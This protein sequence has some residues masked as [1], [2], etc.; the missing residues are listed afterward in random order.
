M[1]SNLT[2]HEDDEVLKHIMYAYSF[3][4]SFSV[5]QELKFNYYDWRN[6]YM[7]ELKI[8]IPIKFLNKLSETEWGVIVNTVILNVQPFLECSPKFFPEYTKHGIDH[9]N[10]VIEITENLIPDSVIN[11]NKLL[12]A[13]DI[14]IL[15]C[16][17][18]IHDLSMFIDDSQFSR[19]INCNEYVCPIK[20]NETNLNL[21]EG[22]CHMAKRFSTE[23]W[24]SLL[25]MSYNKTPSLKDVGR[26]T[27]RDHLFIGD[28]LRLYHHRF[29]FEIALR[30]FIGVE[31]LPQ[32]IDE[33]RK[34]IIGLIAYSHCVKLRDIEIEEYCNSYFGSTDYVDDCPIYYLMV[35][36]R[37]SD[38]LDAGIERAPKE[39]SDIHIFI[40]ETS[41]KEWILNQ[42]FR[43]ESFGW[44]KAN[45]IHTLNLPVTPHSTTE[46][47]NIERRLLGI[48]KEFDESVAVLDEI[49][50]GEYSLTVSR[51]TSNIFKNECRDQFAN[52][53]F[54]N[55]TRL[56]INPDILPL[57]VGPLY[58]NDPA[59]G[60]RE[61]IQNSV[62]ACNQKQIAQKGYEGKINIVID[63]NNKT[64]TI[65]DNGI[66]M[67]EDIVS[68]YYLSAGSSYR[69]SEKWEE[70][71]IDDFGNAKVI[72][73]GRFG[74]GALA[75]FLIGNKATVL[76][77]YQ[78]NKFGYKFIYTLN[79]GESI[80]VTCDERIEE[81]TKITIEMS[82]ES[83]SYFKNVE[84]Q[85]K[86]SEW[87]RYEKPEIIIVVDGK[88]IVNKS[89]LPSLF[90]NENGWYKYNSKYYTDFVW[91]YNRRQPRTANYHSYEAELICNGIPI[92]KIASPY[93]EYKDQWSNIHWSILRGY[94]FDIHLPLIALNDYNG[95]IKLDLSRCVVEEFPLEEAFIE[96]IYKYVIAE[97]MFDEHFDRKYT[98]WESIH[99]YIPI[100]H[101]DKGY[102][103]LAR[104]FILNTGSPIWCFIGSD[105]PFN[106]TVPIGYMH[107][108][109]FSNS[110]DSIHYN[111]KWGFFNKLFINGDLLVDEY[112][113]T[114]CCGGIISKENN[115]LLLIN[116]EIYKLNKD[117]NILT[118]N[119]TDLEKD[120][121]I[122]FELA[123][124]LKNDNTKF[125]KYI[126]SPVQKGEKNLMLKMLQK[127][128]PAK[129]NG[130]W[131]P[132]E[133][134]KRKSMYPETFRELSR[135]INS[136]HKN[137]I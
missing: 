60:V 35:L 133:L 21:W 72:R 44:R 19:F 63:T 40:S 136:L 75:T 118:T 61:L 25:G 13:E 111:A 134:E 55:N 68:N 70:E 36:L 105:K 98:V 107:D 123:T 102:T 33:R 88:K 101:C 24:N 59:Y 91:S 54:I 31:I 67:N 103:I 121:D 110:N 104:S 92:G 112:N 81:G 90:E 27:I 76:T 62:D 17:I 131:I 58:A 15:L 18:I 100:A 37:L 41:R 30:D 84:N 11:D 69:S 82:D 80:D 87:Y 124:Y 29:S 48:Q 45:K 128:I 96:E 113:I 89:I 23:K 85:R 79:A 65:E 53:F 132:Y 49:Y 12:K 73:I 115:D 28:F 83:N 77:R 108:F 116:K 43:Y 34:N 22:Y 114:K 26:W 125:L 2:N 52:N 5:K 66:G 3:K 86:W 126:P 1:I 106:T 127:Y 42:N 20:S 129:K 57:L 130:G 9:I 50:Q 95:Y 135:Y 78:N 56:G 10:H 8:K 39:L 74:I 14:G 117:I 109:D 71:F 64:F 7:S 122:I 47:V 120:N 32:S 119:K 16:S 51:I 137:D 97:L 99:G 4:R 6:I 46:F 38:Y 94:G 93:H